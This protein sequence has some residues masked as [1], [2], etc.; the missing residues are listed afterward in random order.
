[1]RV[2]YKIDLA[3]FILADC[4]IKVNKKVPLPRGND[5][6]E[7]TRSPLVAKPKI[8]NALRV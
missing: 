2:K 8:N 7:Y 5:T 6:V 3:N 1:M 4:G